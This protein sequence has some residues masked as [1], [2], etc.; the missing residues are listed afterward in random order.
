M[1]TA[2]VTG[3][4]GQDGAYLAKLLLEKDY[5]VI[6][7][8]QIDSSFWRLEKLG[9][10]NE[11]EYVNFEL[12]EGT[13]IYKTIKNSSIN[14]FYNLAAQSIFGSTSQM[15]TMTGEINGLGVCRIL[16]SIRRINRSIKFFQ[17]SSSK[18]FGKI[19][20]NAQNEET[21]FKPN[22]PY[23]ISKLLSHWITV[24][25]RE[26]YNMYAV[27]AIL[28][29]HESPLRGLDF[30][31]RK[32]THGAAKIKLGL[33]DSISLGDL[34]VSRDWGYAPD[35]VEAM[36]LMMQQSKPDDYVISSGKAHSLR[37]FLD[38]AF[39]HVGINDWSSYVKVNDDLKRPTE[40]NSFYGDSSKAKKALDWSPNVG[41]DDMI[42][43]MVDSD[44]EL[45]KEE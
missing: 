5:K 43:I 45:L 7:G 12:T 27:S 16:D 34:D 1:K 18:M 24:N 14:E 33:S 19:N 42:R 37:D 22:N 15:P 4:T 20:S 8:G 28:Y 21:L 40:E 6:G 26:S 3:I 44:L 9:I 38:V 10:H 13:N 2:F 29:N 35:Y 11:I 25:Y 32:I 30:V 39:S 41:F 17:A 31:T 23:G 36:W